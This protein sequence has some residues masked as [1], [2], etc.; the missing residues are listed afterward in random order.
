MIDVPE[1][2]HEVRHASRA[3]DLPLVTGPERVTDD[4]TTVNDRPVRKV[5]ALR[6]AK[7]MRIRDFVSPRSTDEIAA[8]QSGQ[9]VYELAEQFKSHR[10]KVFQRLSV[11]PIGGTEAPQN[12]RVLLSRT[13]N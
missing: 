12:C 6:E 10:T 8:Y 2:H 3:T 9:T 11:T 1:H 4:V 7:R 13:A 5:R